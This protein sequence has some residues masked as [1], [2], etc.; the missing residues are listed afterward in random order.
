[1][2]TLGNKIGQP[3]KTMGNKT[4]SGS[5]LGGK[6][7]SNII[8]SLAHND[9]FNIRDNISNS[10]IAQNIPLGLGKHKDSKKSYLEK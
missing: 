6:G 9:D 5:R 2:N 3:F 10:I 7:P 4:S 1:M 8:K